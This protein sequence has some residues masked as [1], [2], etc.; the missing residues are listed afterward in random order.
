MSPGFLRFAAGC[1]HGVGVVVLY[2][3]TAAAFMEQRMAPA[4]GGVAMYLIF[5][6]AARYLR[7][8]SRLEVRPWMRTNECWTWRR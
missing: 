4:Y 7:Y 8:V 6:L 2:F 5:R 1:A 3:G